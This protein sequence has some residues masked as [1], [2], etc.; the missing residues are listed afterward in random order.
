MYHKHVNSLNYNFVNYINNTK[1][2]CLYKLGNYKIPQNIFFPK[3]NTLTIINCNK[4][5]IL[6]IFSPS[7]FPKLTN[8]NYLSTNPGDFKIYE[9]FNNTIEWKFPNK[10]YEFYDFMVK[11]GY[12]KKDSELIKNYITNKKII[13]IFNFII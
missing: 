10:S 6:N 2:L 8:V 4:N 3:V 9:R 5:G 11:S 12:G 13:D 1:H 7:I